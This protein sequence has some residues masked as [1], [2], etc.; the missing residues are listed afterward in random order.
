MIHP[1]LFL[2]FLSSKLQELLHIGD[3]SAN[4]IVYTWL[5][6]IL[7]AI[8]SKLATRAVRLVPGGLQNFMEV[9]VS[10]IENMIVDTM[11]EHGRPYFPLVAT[12]A[13]F[14]LVSN[15]IGLIPGFSHQQPTSTPPPPAQSLCL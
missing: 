2:Q 1:L 6:I 11:G 4:A 5:I 9:V 3:T 7:L 13:I 14:I 15:L 10:G 8:V 12:L